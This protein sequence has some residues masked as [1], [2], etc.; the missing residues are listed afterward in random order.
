MEEI[1]DRWNIPTLALSKL[2]VIGFWQFGLPNSTF[3]FGSARFGKDKPTLR[4]LDFG[5]HRVMVLNP[6]FEVNSEDV[7]GFWGLNLC[8]GRSDEVV[9][10]T[11]DSTGLVK[12][13]RGGLRPR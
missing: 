1:H 5:F 6:N 12:S 8:D 10:S 4:R 11:T 13:P 9:N 2:V 7:R 3:G